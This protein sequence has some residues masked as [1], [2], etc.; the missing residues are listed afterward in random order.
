MSIPPKDSC[1]TAALAADACFACVAGVSV[2]G[3]C[4]I[5][6]DLYI[7]G[8]KERRGKER[9]ER[10]RKGKERKGKTQ[11]VCDVSGSGLRPV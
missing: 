2:Q 10:E 9:K 1:S 11:R 5:L 8:S 4:A 3:G 7:E 6:P